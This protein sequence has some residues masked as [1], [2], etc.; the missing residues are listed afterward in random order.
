MT[1]VLAVL[2]LAAGG[3]FLFAYRWGLRDGQRLAGGKEIQPAK[4][5][6]AKAV[7][8]TDAAR[9]KQIEVENL[10]NYTGDATG[11]KDVM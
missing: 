1:I 8:P 9:K 11:Q 7:P 3:G 4:V 10:M 6:K 2:F 5:A